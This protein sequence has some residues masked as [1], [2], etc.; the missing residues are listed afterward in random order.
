[1]AIWAIDSNL[2]RSKFKA[3]HK[4]MSTKHELIAVTYAKVVSLM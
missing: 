4:A 1:M 3:T 2:A